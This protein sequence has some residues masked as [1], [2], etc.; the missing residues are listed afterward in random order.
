MSGGEL[1]EKLA[2]DPVGRLRWRVCRTFGILPFSH[3][4]RRMTDREVVFCGTQMVLD[5]R[6][7]GGMRGFEGS[8]NGGFDAD[9][10]EALAEGRG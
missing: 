1:I 8:Q 3:A 4:A 7:E 9:R 10:F 5:R 6:E 2:D